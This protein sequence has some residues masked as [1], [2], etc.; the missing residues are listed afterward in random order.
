M[1]GNLMRTYRRFVRAKDGVAAVEFA[2]V[3][4]IL[5]L[6]FLGTYD[7]GTAIAIYMKERAATYSLVAITNQYTSVQTADLQSIVS[8]SSLVLSPYST[9]PLTVTVSQVYIDANLNAKVSW[10]YS[11][12]GNPRAAGSPVGVPSALATPSS[13]LIL[14][15]LSY[16][17]SP[18]FGYFATG[19]INLADSLYVT[20]RS[21]A[22]VTY[23]S[24]NVTSC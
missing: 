15:E 7:A 5:L 16:N 14:G 1:R 23:A 6:L 4:P 3:L 17:Y 19:S 24:A 9:S 13:Y 8:A 22:C 11:S 2:M 12:S 10:S 21:S 20:P 18:S